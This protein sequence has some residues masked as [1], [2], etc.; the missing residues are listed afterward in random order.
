MEWQ[1]GL[2]VC[3]GTYI[4]KDGKLSGRIFSADFETNVIEMVVDSNPNL[5]WKGT[6]Q[7]FFNDWDLATSIMR[8]AT[9]AQVVTICTKFR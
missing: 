1:K 5:L 6:S 3:A 4:S 7:E 9:C 8:V 2:K